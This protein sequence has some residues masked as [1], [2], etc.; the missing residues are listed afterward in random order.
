LGYL[1]NLLVFV[2]HSARVVGIMKQL[3]GKLLVKLLA[4]P[5]ALLMLI[6]DWIKTLPEAKV[7][8]AMLWLYEAIT[9]KRRK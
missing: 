8:A 7:K 4:F 2:G 6:W 5:I 1:E 3:I 9:G